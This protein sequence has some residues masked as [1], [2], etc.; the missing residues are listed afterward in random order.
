MTRTQHQRGF[1]L[2]EVMV[3][4]AIIGI[5][6]A[7]AYPSYKEQVA[8]SRRSDA[9]AALLE[10]AQWMERN[11]TVS[12]DYSKTGSGAAMTNAVLQAAPLQALGSTAAYYTLSFDATPT[13]RVFKLNMVPTGN[14]A[15]D[16]CGTFWVDN[17]GTRDVTTS[18]G[19]T[20]A[21][22]WDK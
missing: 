2:I 13:A 22:C 16:R 14:M 18:S 6:A 5:L 3:V 20:K 15:N 17:T 10:A 8:R 19:A 1:T 21:Q 4:V 11:Y 7:I 12:G 9:K